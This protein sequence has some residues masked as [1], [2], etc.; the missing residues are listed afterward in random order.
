MHVVI[1]GYFGFPRGGAPAARIRNFALGLREC[2]AQ[3]R[4]LS[5]APML[6]DEQSPLHRQLEHDSVPYEKT[7]LCDLGS[8]AYR[9]GMVYSL[10]RRMRW[11]I[12]LYGAAIYTHRRLAQHIRADQ[13]DLLFAYSRSAILVLPLIML[14]R[15]Y[16]IPLV[17]DIS[18]L[19]E[20]FEGLGGSLI[21]VYW[22]WRLG[23]A[24][25]PK[26]FD[27]LGV[28]THG[29]KDKYIALGCKRVIVTPSIE[30]W[31]NLLPVAPNPPRDEFRLVYVGA[32]IDRDAP[33]LLFAALRRLRERGIP[34]V[35]DVIGR[36][37]NHA[38]GRRRAALCRTDP[39]LR[40]CINLIGEVDD[41]DL[42]MHLRAADGL[43][44]M[45]RDAPTE[46][47]SF[48]TRL[49]EYLKHGRP[50]FVSDVGDIARYLRHGVDSMLLS[51]HDAT[52]VADVIQSVINQPDR[53]FQLGIQGRQ[54]GAECFDR[55][56]H[57]ARI[58]ETL[59]VGH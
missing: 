9:P 30:G 22:D 41:Q 27:V 16:R 40:D 3:V 20:Q 51:A 57:A 28:I 2:G 32:L 53:G 25:L 15:R 18:D 58:L 26:Q 37:A 1:A 7:S 45:R 19:T 46:V 49:V 10:R 52:Q 43:I 17:M 8:S 50:V 47:Y 55:R 14:C 35:L 4:V 36:F 11:F 42:S 34:V 6:R 39:L 12:G 31:D 24:Y 44:L 38:E 54:R 21:P 59:N 29:L 23:A 13:C 5:M 56:I 33:D 48:P